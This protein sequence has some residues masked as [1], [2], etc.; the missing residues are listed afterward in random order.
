MH[1]NCNSTLTGVLVREGKRVILKGL[2]PGGL[3]NTRNL[4]SSLTFPPPS[5]LHV[6]NLL[7]V[8]KFSWSPSIRRKTF[9]FG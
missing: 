8:N 9:K 4:E 1:T 7:G 3:V 5:R 6:R 2:V